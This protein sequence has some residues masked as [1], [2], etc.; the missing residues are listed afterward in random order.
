MKQ[1]IPRFIAVLLLVIPGL[2]S[3][4]RISANEGCGIPLLLFLRRRTSQ[5]INSNGGCSSAAFFYLLPA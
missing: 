2:G 4:I 1:V 3:H 5:R